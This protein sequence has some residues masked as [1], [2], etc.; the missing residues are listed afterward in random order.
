MA[1]MDTVGHVTKE[2]Y[3][4]MKAER[5]HE[6]AEKARWKAQCDVYNSRNLE[7]LAKIQPEI[8]KFTGDLARENPDWAPEMS[9]TL[10]FCEQVHKSQ[11]PDTA[12]SFA[13]MI[14]CASMKNKRQS[15]TIE[16]LKGK[17]STIGETMKHVEELTEQVEK[18]NNV[19]LS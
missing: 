7:A 5:D 16:S 11:N 19:S 12:L 9:P 8:V 3:E 18:K 15:E 4:T 17:T 13:R 6:Q 1:E 2:T 10:D 14:H